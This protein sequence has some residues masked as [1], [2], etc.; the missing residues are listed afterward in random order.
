MPVAPVAAFVYVQSMFHASES[1][2]LCRF[3]VVV[4]LTEDGSFFLGGGGVVV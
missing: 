4:N 2:Y 3:V 1:V